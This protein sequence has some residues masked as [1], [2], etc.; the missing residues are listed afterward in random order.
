MS[1]VDKHNSPPVNAQAELS[2]RDRAEVARAV[3]RTSLEA[4]IL[5]FNTNYNPAR[6]PPQGRDLPRLNSMPN[7][8]PGNPPVLPP[9]AAG[10][11][12]TQGQAQVGGNATVQHGLLQQQPVGQRERIRSLADGG[13]ERMNV[14]SNPDANTK[15]SKYG[16]FDTLEPELVDL[17]VYNPFQTETVFQKMR[18]AYTG[19]EPC[20][21]YAHRMGS[22]AQSLSVG[23]ICFKNLLYQSIN[24]L[25]TPE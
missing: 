22:S 5:F 21:D 18:W 8:L 19:Q 15:E 4:M 14:S 20:E 10:G 25:G 23:D 11:G 9:R 3:E 24:P 13:V 16:I 6:G 17:A 12:P 7:R 1:D 2:E